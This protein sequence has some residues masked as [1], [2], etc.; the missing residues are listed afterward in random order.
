MSITA[1]QLK[2]IIGAETAGAEQGIG[3]VTGLLGKALPVAAL[4]GAAAV[5]GIGVAATSMA[6]NFQASMTQLVTGA[7]ESKNNLIGLVQPGNTKTRC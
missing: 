1:A 6:G 3:S 7:G 5:V 2:V 4:A